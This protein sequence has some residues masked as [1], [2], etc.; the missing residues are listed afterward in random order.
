MTLHVRV[1]NVVSKAKALVHV[2][3]QERRKT[4]VNLNHL[5]I[6]L[7]RRKSVPKLC[8]SEPLVHPTLPKGGC[9]AAGAL[10]RRSLNG[11]GERW[12][13][14]QLSCGTLAAASKYYKGLATGYMAAAARTRPR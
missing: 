5:E 3:H 7:H 8:S 11:S 6:H 4:Q 9:G 14:G 2:A 12:T 1:A 13:Q 10:H